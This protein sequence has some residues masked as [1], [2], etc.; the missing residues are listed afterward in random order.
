MDIVFANR[1]LERLCNDDRL[2]QREWGK[3]QAE[4]LRRRLD[5]LRDAQHLGIMRNLPGRLHELKGDLAGCLAMDLRGGNRLILEPAN[6]PPPLK[7][8]GGL[9]WD[10]VTVVRILD[11]GDYHD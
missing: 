3:P 9:D 10:G 7:P 5:D 4:V 8:D 11:V 2:A 1:K 6:D